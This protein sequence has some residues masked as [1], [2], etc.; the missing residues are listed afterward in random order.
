MDLRLV[1]LN[2]GEW[3]EV[4]EGVATR[5]S[6]TQ[7]KGQRSTG[8]SRI[9]HRNRRK[10]MPTRRGVAEGG[11]RGRREGPSVAGARWTGAGLRPGSPGAGS[12]PPVRGRG[13]GVWL[14]LA[15]PRGV[16]LERPRLTR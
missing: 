10:G 13:A 11:Q 9:S 6:P 1:L 15:K 3:D 7:E 16:R 12:V 14:V 4:A 5:G 8:D 2:G